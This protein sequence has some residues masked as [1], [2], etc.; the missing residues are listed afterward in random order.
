MA[1]VFD[2]NGNLIDTEDRITFGNEGSGILPPNPFTSSGTPDDA[3]ANLLGLP[4]TQDMGYLLGVPETSNAG[5]LIGT[6]GTADDVFPFQPP[7]TADD[8]I[9]NLIGTPGTAD[10]VFPFAAANRLQGLDLNRFKGV[11]SLGI[12][13]EEDEE[14]EFLPGQKKSGGIADLFKTILGFAIPGSTFFLDQGRSALDGIKSLNQRLR[15][16]DFAK[17]KTLADYFDAKSYGGRDARDRASAK[18]M[19][20]ARAIQKQVDMRGD[21]TSKIDD[22]DRGSVTTASAAKSKGVGGGGY[23]K[24]DSTRDSFRG[25]Y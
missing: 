7:G 5:Y 24:S 15:N 17:S 8:P 18:T 14:Q 13:N 4:A 12:A 19:R 20:E 3:S 10:D 23:T 1:I 16:T 6:P 11:G 22:R 25:R 2:A 9:A 21:S